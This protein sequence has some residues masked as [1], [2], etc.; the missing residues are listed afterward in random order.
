MIT[1]VKGA[2]WFDTPTVFSV[3]TE[4][5]ELMPADVTTAM[6]DGATEVT[7]GWVPESTGNCMALDTAAGPL[8]AK[9][10]AEGVSTEGTLEA[11]DT[12][13]VPVSFGA[14]WVAAFS[15]CSRAS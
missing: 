9:A 12:T 1:G 10:L 4:E 7:G 15:A 6:D 3:P 5:L 14:G 11:T 8:R 2:W 13:V